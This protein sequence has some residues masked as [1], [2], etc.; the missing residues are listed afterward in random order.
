MK[1]DEK[2]NLKQQCLLRNSIFY[3]SEY[4]STIILIILANDIESNPGPS[5]NN[6]KLCHLNVQSIKRN[7]DKIKH[8]S[9]QLSGYDII[10]LSETWLTSEISEHTHLLIRIV[11]PLPPV[12]LILY[13]CQIVPSRT[14]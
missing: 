13:K 10:T 8:I 11:T 6:I 5:T 3:K 7:T 12:L 4:F 2:C 14:L 9:L 1:F